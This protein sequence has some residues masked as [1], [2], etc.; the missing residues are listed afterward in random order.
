VIAR[1]TSPTNIGLS[2]LST[3][4]AYDFGWIGIVDLADHLERTLD[5]VDR[6]QTF[7][8]HLLNWYD[9]GDLH[10]LEP[11]YV[12]TVDSGNLAGHLLAVAQACREAAE[13][14][15]LGQRV[16][17]GVRD[18]TLLALD[19]ADHPTPRSAPTRSA[20]NIS[21]RPPGR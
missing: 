13:T 7:R 14:P 10:P 17:D 15:V 2:L 9:T 18:A 11:L 6:L 1:R 20:L 19:A 12:S 4:A 5:T 3:T 8:G 21:E 16:L